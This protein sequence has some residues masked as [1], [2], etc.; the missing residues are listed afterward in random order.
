M[1]RPVQHDGIVFRREG[2]S[3]WWM[4]YRDK[5]GKRQRESTFTQDWQEAQKVLR[6]RLEARDGNVLQVVRKGESLS[7]GEWADFFLENYSKPPVRRPGTHHANLRCV[8]HLKRAFATRR[9]IDVGSDE[10]DL[11]LRERL[12]QRIRVRISK[13][14]REHGLIKATTVHQEFR[15]LRRMLNVAVRKRLLTSNPCAMVEFPVTLKGLFRPHYVTWSEQQQIENNAIPHLRNAIRIIAETGLRVKRELLP[16][17]KD[18]IDFLNAVLW[19]P[20]SKTPN[21]VAE[22]PLTKLALESFRE[23][24]AISGNGEFLFPSD[25]NKNGHLRSLRTAW[26]KALKRAGV[27]YFRLYDLRSTYATRLSAGGV[28]DEWVIQMLRQGDSQVFKKYSQMKLQMKR[29]ALDKINRRANEMSGVLT[30]KGSGD[31]GFDTVL[32]Q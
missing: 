6:K 17:K 30:H 4:C 28:A 15:V 14:Y 32:T 20:D 24:V 7:F 10:I 25:L 26:R 11:Y 12:R 16:M 27:P 22:I 18:Q 29:E 31:R 13:G 3:F 9:L 23:Q 1:G 8:Q 21:G 2:S 19:I 5:A